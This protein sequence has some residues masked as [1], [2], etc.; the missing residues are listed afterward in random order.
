MSGQGTTSASSLLHQ[1]N[2]DLPAGFRDVKLQDETLRDGLQG[3]YV[4]TPTL[5][6]KKQLLRLSVRAGCESGVMGFPASSEREYEDCLALV[7]CLIDEKLAYTPHFLARARVEDLASIA[8]IRDATGRH[9]VAD[10]F[11]GSSRLRRAVEGWSYDDLLAKVAA[12][13]KYCH[14]KQLAFFIGIEDMTRSTPEDIRAVLQIATGEGVEA[15]GICDTVGASDP[16]GAAR[17]VG[18]TLDE[19]RAAGSSAG[20]LWHGHNDRG[21]A[22]ANALAAAKAGARWIEG[23]FLGIG[24]RTGNTAL[25]QVILFLTDAGNR[26]FDLMEVA[27]YCGEVARLTQGAVPDGMPIV[28]RQA[29]A[30]FTGTHAAAIIKAKELGRDY[31]DLLFSSVPASSFGRQQVILIG[32][33]SG[34]TNARYVLRELG[35]DDSDVN[36]KRLLAMAKERDRWVHPDDVRALFATVA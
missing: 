15:I 1:W 12:A 33:T 2:D 5:D 30:T 22:L 10:F 27:R 20:V 9:V 18:F 31:E 13:S 25:E 23:T 24:E 29:F 3:A 32:P 7:Q 28:G 4:R 36:A 16:S 21:L 14:S 11:L 6:E 17:L 35:I 19:I 8:G 26:R 34:L